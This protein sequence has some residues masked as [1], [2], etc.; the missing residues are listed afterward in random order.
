MSRPQIVTTIADARRLINDAASSGQQ[1]GFVPTMGALH[2]GH[3]S[4]VDASHRE[5]DF[6]VASIFVNP[7]QFGAGE[8]LERY[9]RTFDEDIA[10]LARHDVDV[11][12]APQTV[13]MY[14]PGCSTFVEP[15]D[16][17]HSLEGQF[18]PSH[19][20]G[21]ATVVLK[22]FHAIPADKAFFGEKDFQQCLVI[23]HM[24]GDL[25]L[26]IE[27]VACPIVRESDGLALSSRNRYLSDDERAR[28]LSISAALL[29]VQKAFDDGGRQASEL[30]RLMIEQLSSNVDSIDYAVVVDANTLMPF[31]SAVC[32]PAVALIAAHVGSTRLIDNRRLC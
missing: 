16:V 27:I 29:L 23:R 2:E 25:N 26:P 19:F 3:L 31:Q 32:K 1:V 17:A 20:R 18:R 24:V 5:C 11:V 30:E 6:H 28:A 7:T 13:E 9:P 4:L 22:L 14:P 10:Q 21:V 15:P 12:F 8:D